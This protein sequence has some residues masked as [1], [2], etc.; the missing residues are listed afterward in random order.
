[1]K[2]KTPF[3]IVMTLLS[4]AVASVLTGG[5]SHANPAPLSVSLIEPSGAL[6]PAPDYHPAQLDP[7]YLANPSIVHPGDQ[8]VQDEVLLRFRS[9]VTPD[10]QNALMA[11]YGLRFGR[12]IYG[13]TAFVAKVAAGT[14]LTVT[15]S[16]HNNPLLEIASVNAVVHGFDGV[17]DPLAPQQEHLTTINAY[18]GWTYSHGLGSVGLV[19]I[20]D[21]GLDMAGSDNIA[22][23]DFAAKY[24]SDRWVSFDGLD[25][26][27]DTTGHGSHVGGLAVADTNNSLYVAGVG[28]TSQP[29]A[30]HVL[31]DDGF[32]GPSGPVANGASAVNWA[33][34]HGASVINM[35]WGCPRGYP[36]C[37][38]ADPQDAIYLL[39]KAVDTAAA[40]NL[41][42]V[43]AGGNL[44]FSGNT[45]RYPAAFGQ[46][47]ADDAYWAYNPQLVIDVAG[48]QADS[49]DNHSVTGEEVD[50]AAPSREGNGN[51]LL[52][53]APTE[54]TPPAGTNCLAPYT[55]RLAGTSM[56]APQIAGASALLMSFGYAGKDVWTFIKAGA[57]DIA[58]P[59]RDDQT[60]WG[61]VNVAL[62]LA[63]AQRTAPGMVV[64]PN[65][66]Q[67]AM[68]WFE[69]EGG[70]F[71]ANGTVTVFW[72]P[73]GQPTSSFTTYADVKG[74][75]GLGLQPGG[76][77]PI[78]AWTVYMRDNSTQRVTPT[79]TFTVL[80]PP[81]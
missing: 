1:M 8:Y 73:P 55:Y 15:N 72:T 42:I 32:C 43:A 26:R 56:S 31:S 80:P 28:Y 79:Q 59:G 61:R 44:D 57:T 27:L 13:D 66:G 38:P 74:V 23:P 14:A 58:P 4:L 34:D 29:M 37:N 3:L 49:P 77:D 17:N 71:T 47:H 25:P 22:H 46:L 67:R 36:G 7:A 10:Q 48:T 12:P 24:R 64:V 40:R 76:S 52:S 63:N 39:K 50:F 33:A 54:P 6:Y 35:S 78:G 18:T 9:D 21:D 60:G 81:N 65:A 45:P 11:A 75:V 53:L 20:I 19:A 68:Q 16:L 62:S 5:N 2:S 69:F 70:G 30:L 41:T 51:G